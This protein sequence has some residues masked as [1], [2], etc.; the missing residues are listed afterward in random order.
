MQLQI[1]YILYFFLLL[2]SNFSWT[3]NKPSK[4]YSTA[5][6]LPNN[7]V[8][9]LFIDKNSDLWIGTENGISTMENGSFTTLSF[10][11]SI[12][13]KSCWDIAQ[14]PNGALW[15]AS[16][17]GGV[18]KFDGKSFTIFNHKNG[19]P[20]DRT[21][22]LLSYKN[23]IYVGT[24][25]GI[26]IIDIKTNKVIVPKGIKPHFEV[27]ITTDFFVYQNQV[28]FSTANEGLFKVANDNGIPTIKHILNYK[29]VY[30]LGFYDNILLSGN[31]GYL[32]GF[33]IEDILSKKTTHQSFGKS[34]VW[35]FVKDNHNTIYA[36]A[37]GVFDL[38]GGLYTIKEYR[39]QNISE[40][41]GIDSK[42]LLNVV[43]NS[44]KDIL[45]VGS[46]DKGIYE[47]LLDKTIEH[48]TF[49]D[50]SIADFENVNNKKVILHQNG[51]SF[52]N[53]QKVILK[54]ISKSDFKKFE[55]A[56]IKSAEKLPT[57]KDGFYELNYNTPASKIEFYEIVKH[58][59]SLWVTSNIGIFELN[60]EGQILHYLPIHSYKIGFTTGHKFIETIPYGGVRVYDDVY[61]LKSKHFSEYDKN[62]PLDI[63]GIVNTNNKTYLISVFKG[64]FVYQNN[65]FESLLNTKIW[66]EEKLK[67]ITKN[68]NG[69]LIISS[70]FDSAYVINTSE[71]F[72]ILK[73]ISKKQI[74]GNTITF[75]ES[76]KDFILIG[77]EKGINIY[78]DN[79]VQLFDKEQGLNDCAITASH[80]FDDELW[81]GTKKGFYTID[82]KKLT[83]KKQTVSKI[84]IR[85]ISINSIPLKQENYSWFTYKSNQLI[86]DYKHNTIT[87]DFL[88]KG[89]SFPNKLKF[90]YRLKKDSNW[91]PSSVKPVV[92]LSY[93]PSDQYNL[94]IEILDLNTGTKS[95]HSIL[96]IIINPPFWQTWWFFSLLLV[97]TIVVITIIIVRIKRRVKQ[98]AHIENLISKSRLETLLSQM[99]PHFTFN[100]MNAIQEYVFAKDAYSSTIYISEFA[101]LMRQT[102]ENSNKLTISIEDEI[103]Y[104]ETYITIE[105]QRFENHIQHQITIDKKIDRYETEIPTMFLQPFVE[106]IFKHA[107]D[108]KNQQPS[109]KIEFILLDKN[110]LE[111]IISDNGKGNKNNSRMHASKG[112]QIT[113]ERIEILQ[114]KNTNPIDIHFSQNGTTVTIQLVI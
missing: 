7:A 28:Y 23:N 41:Y 47:I 88:P 98:K 58:Q 42:N 3:Q 29:N 68:D 36:A 67:F 9:S 110:L 81:L 103:K 14:D 4:N 104:L 43:Y 31:K 76:Y 96:S 55:L 49:N 35:D 71:N 1:K 57:H 92:Y 75:L 61:N 74:I 27:F 89:H 80:I 51:L 105:K 90:R 6:G 100:A 52:I 8:R 114:P 10:P 62:T 102:L 86:C 59:K 25:F 44:K 19:L 93:L 45:Y 12:T 87:L 95:I 73:T 82:L 85:G 60:F 24:E 46:K 113:K 69:N 22:K 18:Y 84:E 99:N 63:V 56:F 5:D 111:I 16:Y 53:A 50:L 79:I 32:D 39:L 17:G 65:E 38:S 13:N 37:W 107:F 11:P 106:N 101:S 112:I 15:F 20:L 72:K 30:S 78:K 54:S 77:T 108:Q 83:A 97:I 70:E 48:N 94:E 109:F 64:L 34:T 40:Q 33:K 2:F 91:S 66:K 26:A 21:R